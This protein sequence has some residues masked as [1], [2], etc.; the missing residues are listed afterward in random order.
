M[1]SEGVRADAGIGANHRRGGQR[2]AVG[3]PHG[4]PLVIAIFFSNE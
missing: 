2:G 3:N 1:C 4:W